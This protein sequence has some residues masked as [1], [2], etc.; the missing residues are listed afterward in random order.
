[1]KEYI[2]YIMFGLEVLIDMQDIT[3]QQAIEST[4]NGFYPEGYYRE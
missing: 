3:I 2:I 4:N 1:M